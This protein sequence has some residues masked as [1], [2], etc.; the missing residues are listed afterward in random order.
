MH[1]IVTSLIVFKDVYEDEEELI[2]V[3]EEFSGEE[4]DIS[5][6]DDDPLAVLRGRLQRLSF[7]EAGVDSVKKPNLSVPSTVP[8]T[9]P[10]EEAIDLLTSSKVVTEYVRRGQRMAAEECEVTGL[11]ELFW[12][13]E[14]TSPVQLRPRTER[15]DIFMKILCSDTPA[16]RELASEILEGGSAARRGGELFSLLALRW[17]LRVLHGRAEEAEEGSNQRRERE[18]EKWTRSE[19]EAYIWSIS[20]DRKD[21]A[22]PLPVKDRSVQLTAQIL[23]AGEAIQW[24]AQALLLMS[25]PISR[26]GDREPFVLG[27]S[28]ELFSGRIFHHALSTWTQERDLS[29]SYRRLRDTAIEDLEFTLGESKG[30]RGKKEKKAK[31]L[32]SEVKPK[33]TGGTGR[34]GALAVLGTE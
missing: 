29:D 27:S 26:E 13:E 10:N 5:F 14:D 8:N 33:N 34:F 21:V 12:N 20:E 30:K 31:Q 25:P 11:D 23:V 18:K 4:D 19:C 3:V 9:P 32:A 24:L 28:E 6:Q 17:V 1:I 22:E 15:L 16:I 2:D 7:S